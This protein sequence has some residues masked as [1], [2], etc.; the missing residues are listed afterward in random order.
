MSQQHQVYIICKKEEYA[1]ASCAFFHHF[2]PCWVRISFSEEE[3]NVPQWVENGNIKTIFIIGNSFENQLQYFHNYASFYKMVW[4]HC[5]TSLTPEMLDP[6]QSINFSKTGIIGAFF[7]WM[8]QISH[9]VSSLHYKMVS[10][11]FEKQINWINQSSL[12]VC[13]DEIRHFYEAIKLYQMDKHIYTNFYDFFS[14]KWKWKDVIRFYQNCKSHY[15]QFYTCK[16]MYESKKILFAGHECQ[17]LNVDKELEFCHRMM[18][19]HYATPLTLCVHTCM[20]FSQKKM[21]HTLYLN[22]WNVNISSFDI[23]YQKFPNEK[24]EGSKYKSHVSILKDLT[25]TFYE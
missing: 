17:V 18:N 1:L 21:I 12:G 16:V 15:V 19:K 23:L 11:K 13:N 6:I 9:P 5:E 3:W 4:F 7:E 10:D 20:D 2:I 25:F 8:N 22:S 24:I 14:G